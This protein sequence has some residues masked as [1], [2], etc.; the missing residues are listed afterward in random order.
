MRTCP[1]ARRG[2][3]RN[4]Q[5]GRRGTKTIPPHRYPFKCTLPVCARRPRVSHVAPLPSARKRQDRAW[6]RPAWRPFPCISGSSSPECTA[7][8]PQAGGAAPR[9]AGCRAAGWRPLGAEEGGP[10]GRAPWLGAPRA[11]ARLLPA[12][13]GPLPCG[14]PVRSRRA[15]QGPGTLTSALCHSPH[16]SF[17][18]SVLSAGHVAPQTPEQQS[19]HRGELDSERVL[20]AGRGCPEALPGREGGP[21]PGAALP[22][23]TP[24][25]PLGFPVPVGLSEGSCWGK[26][27][28]G[29]CDGRTGGS[30]PTGRPGR[31]AQGRGF[32]EKAAVVS[33]SAEDKLSR[34]VEAG[35]LPGERGF[36][37]VRGIL[38][39]EGVGGVPPGFPE[40]DSQHISDHTERFHG[41]RVGGGLC[42]QPRW[43]LRDETRG[44]ARNDG[45][46][47]GGRG[48]GRVALARGVPAR[49]GQALIP[50]RLQIVCECGVLSA[51]RQCVGADMPVGLGS[52]LAR[53]QSPLARCR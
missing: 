1:E 23:P 4:G 31:C 42:R 12:G 24:T 39:R 53:T 14:R 21:G 48:R 36:S 7:R 38:W 46:G 13:P 51:G 49:P 2:C 30:S 9:A 8:G 50:G 22:G 16:P 27:G 20:P 15:R 33:I 10:A 26:R 17:L 45:F 34:A 11:P 40:A 5:Q 29:G 3:C 35:V 6:P 44:R 18:S 52:A 19:S 47:A 32:R 28:P 41:C 25:V 43:G 37:R